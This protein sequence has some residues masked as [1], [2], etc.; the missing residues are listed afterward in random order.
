M[1]VEE[2]RHTGFGAAYGGEGSDPDLPRVVLLPIGNVVRNARDRHHPNNPA[3]D[4]REML[5]NLLAGAAQDAVAKAIDDLLS[6]I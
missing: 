2:A 4:A 3:F 6:S 1:E 5:D